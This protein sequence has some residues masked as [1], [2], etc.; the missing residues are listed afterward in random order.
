MFIELN[1]LPRHP[2]FFS[3]LNQ[4]IKIKNHSKDK[5]TLVLNDFVF[6]SMTPKESNY[7]QSDNVTKGSDICLCY[8]SEMFALFNVINFADVNHLK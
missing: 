4:R 8:R 3:F 5:S 6:S 2:N 7:N 1:A